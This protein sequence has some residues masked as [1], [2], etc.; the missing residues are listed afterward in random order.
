MKIYH[1]KKSK[2]IFRHVLRLYRKKRSVLSDSSRAEIT[3]S[4]N[5]LQTC[6]INKDR[7][8]AHEKAKQAELLSSVHLKRSSFTRGRDFIIGLAFCLVVAILIRSLWFELYEIPTGSMR[9]TLR[10]KD[11]L[12]VSKTNF[13]IN[14]PLSR[15]HLYFDPNLIL[16]NGIFTF[17]GAGMDIA[18]VDTLYFYIFPGKKQFVKRLMGKPGDTLYFYGGQLYGIDKEG[19]D[20]SKKLAPEYLDHI[21]H[22]PYIYLNGKVD[23]PS[24]LVGGV[25]SPVTLRQ[26]N[27]KVATLSISSHQKVSGKL[28]PPFERFEDYYDLWGFKD[29]GIGRLLTRDEVGKLTDTPLSQLENAA[30][31]LEII[32]HPSIKYPKIIR[33]HAGRLVPGV[34][35]TSSVLP[36]TEEH[37][38]VLMSHLYTARFIVK[39]GKMARYGSPIKAEKGC[40][41]CPDLPGVPDGTYEF[42]YGKGYKVHFGGLRTSLPEDHPLYQFT[43]KRVQLLF[44]LGIECLTPYAP[45]VKDQSLLPS[46]YIYY[47][48]GDL[49]AMGGMLM[50]KEDPTLVKFLQQEKLRESSAPSYRPHFPFDDP[51]P[52]LKKDG[53]LDIARIQT[54]GLKIPEKHYLGLGDNYAMSADSRD[55]GFIPED[56]VRGAPDF[57][58]WPIG[59]GMGP[60]TQASYPFFN[61]P[62]TIVWILAVIGFGSYYLYHKKRYGLPQDID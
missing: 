3:K 18:D 41:Y 52:P 38:K 62:R 39:E 30:L 59:D 13:G 51:G 35:T 33:D 49:Y 48:D 12:I 36:L 55:F 60:P 54:Q 10:E 31:Y 11:S 32:H 45:L 25:Y 21:D 6:L 20:I 47:R 15:G 61:L 9:P 44:N 43:P 1:L 34:G 19:K 7:A 46:R 56:N 26:M 8:G 24:R 17:T 23:L 29:Y 16:R 22:V 40:R 4:L 28:L 53:S 5:G 58:F 50:Q 2:Q 42:Y 37:L 14:I 27:Q 57:V